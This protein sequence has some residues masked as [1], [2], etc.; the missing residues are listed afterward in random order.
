MRW[1]SSYFSKS[2]LVIAPIESSFGLHRPFSH[3]FLGL[4]IH[5]L[6][7]LEISGSMYT[8]SVHV[9]VLLVRGDSTP[10]VIA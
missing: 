10:E 2:S 9:G 7:A 6:A 3:N 5:S 8:R 4:H 1:R